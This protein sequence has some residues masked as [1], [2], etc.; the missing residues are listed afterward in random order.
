[1][2]RKASTNTRAAASAGPRMSVLS[3]SSPLLSS[4]LRPCQSW[5]RFASRSFTVHPGGTTMLNETSKSSDTYRRW[6]RLKSPKESG[7]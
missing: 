5:T 1:M 3:V 6:C 7:P 4:S 2:P